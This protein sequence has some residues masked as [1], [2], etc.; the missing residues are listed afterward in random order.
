MQYHCGYCRLEYLLGYPIA[1]ACAVAPA[2]VTAEYSLSSLIGTPTCS[3]HSD[4]VSYE[5][6]IVGREES[7]SR[8]RFRERVRTASVNVHMIDFKL[9]RGINAILAHA[10]IV[11]AHAYKNVLWGNF[12][13]WVSIELLG[14]CTM[15]SLQAWNCT[16]CAS[17]QL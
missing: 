14:E 7:G 2:T 17:L 16:D 15:T 1:T 5:T 10:Y 8:F 9:T 6:Y 12:Y 4:T 11:F 3:S 13:E